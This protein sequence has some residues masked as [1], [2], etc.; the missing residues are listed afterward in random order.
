MWALLRRFAVPAIGTL[1]GIGLEI[2]D[3]HNERLAW[4]LLIVAG[5]WALVAIAT[6]ESVR[7]RLPNM[8]Y[9]ISINRVASREITHADLRIVPMAVAGSAVLRFDNEGPKVNVA[10]IM[11]RI[12]D[13]D[14]NT[15]PYRLVWSPAGG[16]TQ[17]YN[18]TQKVIDVGEVRFAIVA[19]P[20]SPTMSDEPYFL[21]PGGYSQGIGRWEGEGDP[22]DA[23]LEVELSVL[24]NPPLASDLSRRTYLLELDENSEIVDF[25]EATND[26]QASPAASDDSGSSPTPSPSLKV[27]GSLLGD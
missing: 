22:G 13:W 18:V 16:A 26:D 6:L 9:T 19:E 5:A 25:R 3:Y 8:P 21:M 7:S 23:P 11:Q 14:M 27:A 4:L 20:A 1:I 15:L 17:T 24:T 10:V 12:D 2:G